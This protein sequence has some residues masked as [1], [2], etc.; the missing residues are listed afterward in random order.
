[1]NK[2]RHKFADIYLQLYNEATE[3][4]KNTE[5]WRFRKRDKLMHKIRWSRHHYKLLTGKQI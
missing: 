2:A 4:Y 3:E 1:M 5:W